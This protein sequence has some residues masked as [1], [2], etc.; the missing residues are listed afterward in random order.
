MTG[1]P[2]CL[3]FLRKRMLE[4]T[5]RRLPEVIKTLREKEAAIEAEM[6]RLEEARKYNDAKNLKQV[7]SDIVHELQRKINE[8]LDGSLRL[9]QKLPQKLQILDDEMDDEEESEWRHK[10]LN[11][12]TAGEEAWREHISKNINLRTLDQHVQPDVPLVGGK[13][14]QRAFHFFKAVMIERLPE[15]F[16]LKN[17]VP[18][19]LG[20]LRGGLN[21]EDWEHATVE[22]IKACMSK[23]THPGINF[24]VKHVG[25]IFRRFI[26]IALEDCKSGEHLSHTFGL[27]PP[28]VEKWLIGKY[29]TMIW[30]LMCFASEKTHISLEPMYT[31]VNP[32]LPTFTSVATHVHEQE[33]MQLQAIKSGAV[34]VDA[35]DKEIASRTSSQNARTA[36]SSATSTVSAMLTNVFS[37]GR[38]AKNHMMADSKHRITKKQVFLPGDR[39]TMITA[40]EVD[41]IVQ[42]SFEYMTGLMQF[43][44]VRSCVHVYPYT[45]HA[46]QA[47]CVW[48]RSI[49]SSSSTTTY[50]IISKKSVCGSSL[51]T[52]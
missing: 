32:N 13:Q 2:T 9:A 30:E 21:R 5:A 15:P 20:A 43:I 44:M 31:T 45:R 40:G 36:I 51:V 41:T 4:D 3:T 25:S 39:S 7:V 14:Y 48:R 29:D 6:S 47:C 34:Q 22:I 33:R 42:T 26:H 27:L 50:S 11:Q 18:T 8:Y 10:C 12:Y 49:W 38:Q 24:F 1:F 35:K 46:V 28:H 16:D 19:A 23:V 52:S 37:D 17:L